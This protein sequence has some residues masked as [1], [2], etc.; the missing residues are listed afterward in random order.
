MLNQ[1]EDANQK[2]KISY[3]V[4]DEGFLPG[5][6]SGILGEPEP[7]Q[8]IRRQTHTLPPDEHHQVVIGQHQRQHEKHEQ[9]QIG[10]ETVIAG[11]LRHVAN[12][13]DVN[14]E[15][16]SGDDQ[17]HDQRELIQIKREI[18]AEGTGSNPV[19]QLK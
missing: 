9:V 16:N 1:Q 7:N 5:R 13:V 17:Q 2:S 8:Q 18:D 3:A 6:R 19:R 15:T 4:N 10:E 14:E 12:G 11:I